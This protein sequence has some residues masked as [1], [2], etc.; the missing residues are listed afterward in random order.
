M[1]GFG[2]VIGDGQMDLGLK[3][4]SQW[5]P[6]NQRVSQIASVEG[7]NQLKGGKI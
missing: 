7:L 3:L 1:Q 5:Y 2:P 6:P 4:Q